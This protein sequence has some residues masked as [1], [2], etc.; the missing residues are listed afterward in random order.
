MAQPFTFPV[1]MTPALGF[2]GL[3][4]SGAKLFFYLSGTTTP[5]TVYAD[6]ALTTPL[7]AEVTADIGGRFVAIFLDGAISYRAVLK[8]ALGVTLGEIDPIGDD[9]A[10]ELAGD[11]GA[12]M[13][14]FIQAIT[15]AVART[16]LA[17][18]RE[19]ISVL[20]FGA[21]P[22][23]VTDST[24]AFNLATSAAAAH[25]GNTT[26]LKRGIRI[27]AGQYKVNGPVYVRKGQHLFGDGMGATYIDASM[28]SNT[29]DVFIL[30]TKSDGTVDG[31]GLVA[32]VSDLYVIGGPASYAVINTTACAG[33]NVHGIMFSSP[34]IGVKAGG[35]DGLLHDCIFDEGLNHVVCSGIN[36]TISD[37]LFYLGNYQ[38]TVLSNAADIEINDGHFEYAKYASVYLNDGATG[39]KGMTIDGCKFVL[40]E[41][42]T[43]FAGFV[44]IRSIGADLIVKGSDFC[45]AKGYSIAA[46]AG[47]NNILVV[48]G[49]LFDG[50]KT[51]ADYAQSTTAAG[52]EATN[53]KA[54][55]QGSVFRNLPGIPIGFAGDEVSSLAVQGNRFLNNTNAGNAEIVIAN[56]TAGS[57][58]DVDGF[59]IGTGRA[60]VNAQGTVP[61]YAPR[62]VTG[63]ATL[64]A[65]TVT[66][67]QALVRSSSRIRVDR[68]TDGGTVGASYS[69]ARTAGTGFT[70]TAKDGAGATQALDTSIVNWT[71]ELA[72]A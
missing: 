65:G 58:V 32:E 31:G 49:C 10:G 34:G 3:I 50:N 43:T 23:G 18:G 69:I 48:Q 61:V 14:G 45:N 4:A 39:I 55:I 25:T 51:V 16:L 30:G 35:A 70:I 44:L 28:T 59:I 29:S 22:T 66:V 20:D 40:N 53:L 63:Q 52:I 7:G 38:I 12:G 46:P 37:N 42:F 13:I 17:K 26:N 54:T 47:V 64:V 41:Q 27:P 24:A 68:Q 62:A 71:L 1:P 5:A 11:E 6:A 8:T 15:G 19:S 9:L 57:R 36:I 2:T 21:D 60:I 33:W 72:G 56:T 67:T